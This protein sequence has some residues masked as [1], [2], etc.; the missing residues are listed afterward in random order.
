MAWT[1]P[2]TFVDGAP[3]TA[4][5]L[6]THLRDNFLE[7]VPAK[8][9]YNGGA[10]GGY[11]TVNGPYS[12]AERGAAYHEV[13]SSQSTTSTA[14]TDL[15]TP[16]PTTGVITGTIALVFFSAQFSN[17]QRK[18]ECAIGIEVGG[19]TLKEAKDDVGL[20]MC[21]DANGSIA[22]ATSTIFTDLTPGYNTFTMKYR[23]GNDT[24]TF[25]NRRMLVLPL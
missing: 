20:I 5:Q 11:F 24:A 17:N 21:T 12:I 15:N 1:T 23:A 6:N 8:S 19:K 7:T 25:A 3:L 2:M 18:G 22:A 10:G 14:Y 9:T 4:A 16:G 13:N